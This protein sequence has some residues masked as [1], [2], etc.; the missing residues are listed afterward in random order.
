MFSSKLAARRAIELRNQLQAARLGRRELAKLGLIAGGAYWLKGASLRQALA[1]SSASPRTKPWEEPLPIPAGAEH[2]DDYPYTPSD[3]QYCNDRFTPKTI[4]HLRVKERTQEFAKDLKS[5][6]WTYGDDFGG[7]LIDFRYGEPSCLH[8]ENDLPSS[9]EHVGFGH[10]EIAPHLHNFH[11]ASESDGGPWNWTHPKGNLSGHPNSRTHHYCMAYAGF[12]LKKGIPAKWIDPVTGG[13]KREALTTLFIHDHRPE[14][15][16]AN[17]YK[18]MVAMVRCFDEDDTGDE[19][20]G[21]QLPSGAYDVPLILADKQFDPDTGELA[22]NQFSIDG[23]LGDKL[24][25]NGKIQPYMEVKRRKYRFRILNGGPSRFYN[26]VLRKDGVSQTFDQITKSGNLLPRTLQDVTSVDLWVAERSDIVIDF[27]KFKKGDKLYLSNN[28]VMMADGR[29]IDR[30][31][32][33]NPDSV[34]NQIL[35]FRV[36]AAAEDPSRVPAAFRP[37]PSV[38]MNEVVKIREWVLGRQNGMWTINGK[39][40]DPDIDHSPEFMLNPTNK[41]RRN[42][43]EVWK[44]RSTSGGWDHPM[45]IHFEEGIIFTQ[46]GVAVPEA[47]R[48]RTDI[49]RMGG[50]QRVDEI[51]VFLRFRDFPDPAYGKKTPD[52]GRYVMHCHNTMHEDHAMMA[53]WNIVA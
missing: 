35:E 19:T 28:L 2:E 43:A 11:S 14:F 33:T 46:N 22:F 24:T 4:Y 44:I 29:G 40:W 20:T 6:V 21:W 36:G 47:N 15:T 7:P 49:Y 13:D 12:D 39:L 1:A 38:N 48:Y 23:W 45:H 26:L 27:R 37:L 18:G 25:V 9:E 3:Y 42:S 41:V 53:T 16:A 10:P 17:V 5:K 52:T 30:G 51:E 34:T 32:T 50:T 8:I 31:K